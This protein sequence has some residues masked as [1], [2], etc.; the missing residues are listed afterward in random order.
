MDTV[1]FVMD[2][3]ADVYSRCSIT[4]S[5]VSWEWRILT[6]CQGRTMQFVC[7]HEQS[8][9]VWGTKIASKLRTAVLF[10]PSSSGAVRLADLSEKAH[11]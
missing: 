2:V 6:G 3:L 1:L 9:G 11:V 7:K 4:C 8:H 5:T 10:K